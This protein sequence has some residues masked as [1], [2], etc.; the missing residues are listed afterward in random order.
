MA[1][2]DP[3]STMWGAKLSTIIAGVG[4]GI[5]RAILLRHGWVKSCLGVVVG[6][7]ASLQGTPIL[8]A[9]VDHYGY[10]YLPDAEVEWLLSSLLGMTGLT[11]AEVL[12]A[13]VKSLAQVAAK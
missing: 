4:G 5:V 3:D 6:L 10:D 11:I 13:R 2:P 12:L 7:V 9:L 1:W 8:S